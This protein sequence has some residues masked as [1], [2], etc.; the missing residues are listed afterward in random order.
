MTIADLLQSNEEYLT[1]AQIAPILGA[2]AHTI[3]R[4]A[5]DAPE[6][7]GFPVIIMGN[8]VKIPRIPFLRYMGVMK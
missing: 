5:K 6:L 2:N 1:S 3:R 8:R 4:Q 7:L